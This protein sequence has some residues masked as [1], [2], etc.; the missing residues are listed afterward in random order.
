MPPCFSVVNL[1]EI[2][3]RKEAQ[4]GK[5]FSEASDRVGAILTTVAAPSDWFMT[6]SDLSIRANTTRTKLSTFFL[7]CSKYSREHVFSCDQAALQMVFSVCPS[8]L[9]DYVPII[10]SSWNFQELLTM[11]KVR[12]MQKVKVRGQ[13]S[14][15][16]RS[17]PN[18]TVSGL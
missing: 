11:T 2:G 13:R 12:Y 3:G 16:Q 6:C 18:L 15:A 8:H 5:N 4:A 1:R 14:R 7:H 9:F 17:Q 10:V